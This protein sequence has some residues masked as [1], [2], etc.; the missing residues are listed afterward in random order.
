MLRSQ[1]LKISVLKISKEWKLNYQC[2]NKVEFKDK[3]DMGHRNQLLQSSEETEQNR[4]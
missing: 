2:R 4:K 1:N 3:S